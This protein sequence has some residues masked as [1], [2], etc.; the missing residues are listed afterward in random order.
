MFNF[1]IV[2]AGIIA[3]SHIEAIS[4][5]NECRL[6]AI[7]DVV[8]E[9]AENAVIGTGARAYA[10]YK[11]MAENEKLD[12]V[13]LNLPHFLHCDVS[14][15]F[16]ERG[17]HTLV[18]KPMANTVA[19]CEK[20]IE[21]S[22]K[23]GAKLAIAHPQRFFEANRRVKR[24]IEDETFG[25]LTMMTEVRNTFYFNENRPKWFLDK[26]KAG[27][28]ILM[29]YFAHTLDKWFYILDKPVEEVYAQ[30]GSFM[31]GYEIEGNAQILLKFN[32]GISGGATFCAYN[33]P[34]AY[35]TIYYFNHG[36]VKLEGTSKLCIAKED[37]FDEIECDNYNEVFALQLGEFIKYINNEKSDIVLPERGMEI[38]KTIN[39]AYNEYPQSK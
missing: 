24:F 5:H 4:R 21:S 11:E 28:G 14:V 10:D 26:E 3:Q 35:E 32:G 23:S 2:G 8:K 22:I 15:F 19:E 31:E 39:K 12:A 34:P 18:E 38:I 7:A 1:G 37:K 6:I 27:G 33:T 16:L 29:N 17:I 13:I 20:M 30:C 36:T 9:R 25:K